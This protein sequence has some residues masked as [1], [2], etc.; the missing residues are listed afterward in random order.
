MIGFVLSGGGNRGAQEVGALQVLL[1]HGVKPDMVIGTSAGAINAAL[2]ASNPTVEGAHR[3]TQLWEHATQDNIYPGS[4]WSALWRLSIGEDSLYPNTHFLDFVR[5]NLQ[6]AHLGN[7]DLDTAVQLYIVATRLDTGAAH[8]F[9]DD[10]N[11]SL[12]DALMATTALPPVHPPWRCR[13]TQYIDGAFTANLPIRLAIERGAREIYALHVTNA[14]GQAQC[15]NGLGDITAC[16]IE[17]LVRRQC[18]HELEAARKSKRVA[19][20]YLPLAGG[21]GLPFE[22]FGHASMLI[23]A[24]RAATEKYLQESPR[25]RTRQTWLRLDRSNWLRMPRAFDG[26]RLGASRVLDKDTGL[27]RGLGRRAN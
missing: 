13:G 9:G 14:P 24:G 1:E 8:V 7:F 10:P 17:T 4:R 20:H 21:M 11:D 18:E 27:S 26:R 5:A 16:A 3:L 19:L 2:L 23:Q 12:V 25:A 6:A 22:D 15:P